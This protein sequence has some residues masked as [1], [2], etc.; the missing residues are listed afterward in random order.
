MERKKK[1]RK[2]RKASLASTFLKHKV[3]H[4]LDF[5]LRPSKKIIGFFALIIH[6]LLPWWLVGTKKYHMIMGKN[7]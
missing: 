7:N 2:K 5:T 6:Q 1:N 4:N 3:T